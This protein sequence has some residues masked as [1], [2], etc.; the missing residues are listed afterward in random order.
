MLVE[1]LADP[2]G[3]ALPLDGLAFSLPPLPGPPFV[4][5]ATEWGLAGQVLPSRTVDGEDRLLDITLWLEGPASPTCDLHVVLLVREPHPPGA[6]TSCT[7]IG[8]NSSGIE[9][10]NPMVWR[11][12]IGG[13]APNITGGFGCAPSFVS[14]EDILTSPTLHGEVQIVAHQ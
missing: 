7:N 13:L 2:L 6:D 3:E 14:D 11:V 1:F 9:T 4:P 5:G 12:R 10:L 8:A